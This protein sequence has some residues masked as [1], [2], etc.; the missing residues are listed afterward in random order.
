MKNSKR[1]NSN[2]T[3]PGALPNGSPVQ[4]GV[5]SPKKSNPRIPKGV[6]SRDLTELQRMVVADIAWNYLYHK[7]PHSDWIFRAASIILK[8]LKQR[9]PVWFR[10]HNTT[11]PTIRGVLIDLI[12]LQVV[13]RCPDKDMK[14][15][16]CQSRWTYG[17]K[18]NHIFDDNKMLIE[19]MESMNPAASQPLAS[20]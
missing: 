9:F 10:T 3:T 6:I 7:D 19:Y 15:F 14:R 1:S 12:T 4:P 18:I 11:E 17:Y 13:V 5:V 20:R 2:K 8:S 16:G